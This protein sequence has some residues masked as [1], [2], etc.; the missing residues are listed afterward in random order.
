SLIM[1]Q[2]V[3][4]AAIIGRMTLTHMSDD[5]RNRICRV[6]PHPEHIEDL[7]RCVTTSLGNL[8]ELNRR[9][10]LW[11]RRSRLNLMHHDSLW[12]YVTVA[13]QARRRLADA[14][15][16]VENNPRPAGV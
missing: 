1:C 12:R 3:F 2:Q 8:L 7:P 4:S 13:L 15:A 14:V 5:E 6:V 16:V 9:L 10:P 11:L